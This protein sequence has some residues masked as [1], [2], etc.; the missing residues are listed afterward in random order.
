MHD[1]DDG[2][3]DESSHDGLPDYIRALEI[4]DLTT[5][6]IDIGSSTSHLM[7]SDVE[8]QRQAQRLSSK[9]VVVSRKVRFR[10]EILL[11]PF[12]DD[13]LIDAK[14]LEKF[15]IDSYARAGVEPSE[16]DTGAVILTGE[17]LK[18]TNARAIADLFATEG[19]R[20]VCAS[21]GHLL[22]AHM[23]ANGSGVLELSKEP[24]RTILNVDVG[25]GTTKFALVR[26]G[27]ILE[28]A[29][30]GVGGRLLAWDDDYRINRIEEEGRLVASE[31]G[32]ELEIGRRIEIADAEAIGRRLAQV[33]V[34]EIFHRSPDPLSVELRLSSPLTGQ[35]E[36]DAFSFSGGVAE[37]IYGRETKDFGDLAPYL[38]QAI[39]GLLADDEAHEILTPNQGIR[40]TVTGASQF[41]FQVSGNTVRV[42]DSAA[43]PFHNLPVTRPLVE[44]SSTVDPNDIAQALDRAI[45]LQGGEPGRV[46]AIGLSWEGP[47][48]HARISGL[49]HG[50]LKH[51][52]S[53]DE[54]ADGVVVLLDADIGH[55]LGHILVDELGYGGQ[56]VCLDGIEIG[57][58]DFVDIGKVLEPSKVVPVIIKS[59]LF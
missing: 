30:I 8:L 9:F 7:I 23:A 44:L 24:S 3:H 2:W 25:G 53:S 33:L 12:S 29:A 26:N 11:T 15:I 51:L 17:A 19:G 4:V 36:P 55:A 52:S 14:V 50:I 58:F 39:V 34:N 54:P 21:A 6:G 57:E 20:F 32:V 46:R 28:S 5:I 38:A 43:L 13:G 45:E 10:S 47:P 16:I 41:S 35:L 42:T 48:T 56:V 31:M 22:E 1:T 27:S 18:R 59:L 37:Y 40:A 49:A